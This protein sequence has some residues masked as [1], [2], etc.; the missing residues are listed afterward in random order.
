[1]FA[2]TLNQCSLCA[3]EN[4]NGVHYIL[5]GCVSIFKMSVTLPPYITSSNCSG[6]VDMFQKT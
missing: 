5:H 1:M 6:K 4:V 2:E 3:Q